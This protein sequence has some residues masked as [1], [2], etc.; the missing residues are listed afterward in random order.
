MHNVLE[1]V[2]SLELKLLLKVSTLVQIS[3][4]LVQFTISYISASWNWTLQRFL[5]KKHTLD[6]VC[7]SLCQLC[8]R[9]N[10]YAQLDK[11]LRHQ[12]CGSHTDRQEFD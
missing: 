8:N 6:Q 1:G 12:V 5:D 10:G 11:S 4:S 7:S 9:Q 3:A 2:L